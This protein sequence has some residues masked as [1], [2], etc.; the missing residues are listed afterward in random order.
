MSVDFNNQNVEQNAND[1]NSEPVDKPEE[2]QTK[3]EKTINYYKFLL[4]SVKVEIKVLEFF[5]ILRSCSSMEISLWILS[6]CIFASIPTSD[7]EM[8]ESQRY[9]IWFHLLHVLRAVIG[10][11]LLY[12][13]PKT[14]EF[15]NLIEPDVQN[16]NE[17]TYNDVMRDVATRDIIPLIQKN[18]CFLIVYGILTFVNFVIDIIDFVSTLANASENTV[19]NSFIS[20]AFMIISISYISKIMMLN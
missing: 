6:I 15:I 20:F 13:L 1:E 3:T 8:L 19:E 5:N 4:N 11:M 17:K 12:R 14:Y 10:I 2:L 9:V 16:A 18:K 7:D